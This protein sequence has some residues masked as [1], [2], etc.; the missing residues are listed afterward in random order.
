MEEKRPLYHVA[1]VGLDPRDVRLIEIVFRHCRY[2]R[3]EY[4]LDAQ[5]DPDL[6]D[7]LIVNPADSEGLHAVTAVRKLA[8]HVPVIAALQRGVASP[9]RHAISVDRLTLQLLPTLN[10]V[11][12]TDLLPPETQP[13]TQPMFRDEPSLPGSGRLPSPT[14][15]QSVPRRAAP[16]AATGAATGAFERAGSGTAVASASRPAAAAPTAASVASTATAARAMAPATARATAPATAA[17][18]ATDPSS[19]SAAADARSPSTAPASRIRVLVVDDSPTVRQQLG[20]AF[21][22]MGI[23]C[24][25][26]ASG[27]QALARLANAHYDLVMADV[28]IPDMDGYRLTREIRRRHRGTPVIILSSR[29][30]PFDYARGMLAGCKAYL[31][32]P[33]PLRQLEASMMKVLRKSMRTEDLAAKLQATARQAAAGRAAAAALTP[34]MA[35]L[36]QA[37]RA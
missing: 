4:A 6:I 25:M 37:R 27:E 24:E 23:V 19:T 12:E 28:V 33:V 14:Q 11:V 15:A 32:K 31:A 13:M 17:R 35:S 18:R 1:A 5:I 21:T 10:R 26:A 9:A 20:L 7:I 3:F 2:N 8:R 34:G 30:A 36:A 16:G 22:Q 29:S